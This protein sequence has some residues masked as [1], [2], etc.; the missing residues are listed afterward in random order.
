MNNQEN[1][2]NKKY[3]DVEEIV[4]SNN[5]DFSKILEPDNEIKYVRIQPYEDDVLRDKNFLMK[6]GEICKQKNITIFLEGTFWLIL[7]IN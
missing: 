3:F 5:L 1:D 6:I 4:I 2:F 7:I